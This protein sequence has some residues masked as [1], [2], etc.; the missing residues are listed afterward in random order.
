MMRP[1]EERDAPALARIYNQAMKPGIYAVP[2]NKPVT[3][4]D[5]VAWLKRFQAPFGAWV[6]ET[7]SGDVQGWCSLI[8]FAVRP[9][10][11]G[12]AEISAYVD[13][14]HRASGIGGLLLAC[15][16]SEARKRGLRSLVSLA[17]EKNVVSI[18][19]CLQAGFRPMALLPGVATFGDH[20]ENVAWIQK[21]LLE[22]DPPALRH[23]LEK[24]PSSRGGAR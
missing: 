1:A 7:P 22:E 12:I 8:P 2:V 24:V 5:R 19:G 23:L 20:F 21:D 3:A 10:Y 16:V 13:E 15:L 4:E 17:F 11:P 14:T 9:S 6:Y 18:S